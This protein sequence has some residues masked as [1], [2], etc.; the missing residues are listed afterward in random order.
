MRSRPAVAA[1]DIP[2]G[3]AW[4]IA[5][6]RCRWSVGRR[7]AAARRPRQR[8]AAARAAGG[9]GFGRQRLGATRRATA[10]RPD[11]ASAVPA[12]PC[13][14][15]I[16]RRSGPCASMAF[17]L[18]TQLV[19]S[20]SGLLVRRPR[21]A[22][23]RLTAVRSQAADLGRSGRAIAPQAPAG[24]GFR[25][26]ANARSATARRSR[27][28]AQ[29]ARLGRLGYSWSAGAF[30]MAE[31]LLFCPALRGQAPAGGGRGSVRSPI[32]ACEE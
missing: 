31:R 9:G 29:A 7:R 25:M 5:G 11:R 24:A 28:Q 14:E 1:A 16:G 3:P 10:R 21:R 32:R 26:D 30:A 2:V 8:R 15:R 4:T 17:R 20:G 18:A 19:A 22:P 6:L 27:R 23:H 12:N 13:F